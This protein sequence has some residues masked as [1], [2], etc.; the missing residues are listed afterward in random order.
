MES[1]RTD[2]PPPHTLYRGCCCFSTAST[3]RPARLNSYAAVAPAGPI[4][5]I[6]TSYVVTSGC[7]CTGPRDEREYEYNDG[8]HSS[9]AGYWP[10]YQPMPYRSKRLVT[11]VRELA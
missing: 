5:T 10:K 9:A 8:S 1:I 4:P 3:E 6:S 2:N 7:E 11:M